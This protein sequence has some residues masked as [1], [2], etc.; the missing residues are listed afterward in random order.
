MKGKTSFQ[1]RDYVISNNSS[2]ADIFL[3]LLCSFVTDSLSLSYDFSF[4]VQCFFVHSPL[5]FLIPHPL[6]I[7]SFVC[8]LPP[9][10]SS[11]SPAVLLAVCV[12]SSSLF[13]S[14]SSHFSWMGISADTTNHMYSYRRNWHVL[15]NLT[16]KKI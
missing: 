14:S 3:L 6:L 16:P 2:P 8:P 10:F 15:C 1:V 7:H 12:S 11:F 9:A 4:C 13:L 5:L